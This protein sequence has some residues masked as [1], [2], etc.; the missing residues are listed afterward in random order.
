M[1]HMST[2]D[3]NEHNP[4]CSTTRTLRYITPRNYQNLSQYISRYS[5]SQHLFR[6]CGVDAKNIHRRKI[7]NVKYII[8]WD[9]DETILYFD[10]DTQI[11]KEPYYYLK[12]GILQSL[13]FCRKISNCLNILWSMGQH[14]YVHDA[15]QKLNLHIYFDYILTRQEC[16]ESQQ[17]YAIN[18]AYLYLLDYLD[19][20]QGTPIKSILIDDKAYE[21]S[22]YKLFKTTPDS[23]YTHII[24][25]SPFNHKSILRFLDNKKD[26]GLVDIY[27]YLFAFYTK[28]HA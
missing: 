15:V 19:I 12:P 9:L 5:E 11:K 4:P 3:T 6:E 8:V 17:R 1:S 23:T 10:S 24:Q 20:P 7:N 21:N 13:Y 14:D 25:P 18:K 2:N 27:N 16:D 22:Q 26:S 28:Y